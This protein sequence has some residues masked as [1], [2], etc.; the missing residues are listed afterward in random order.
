LIDAIAVVVLGGTSLMSGRGGIA[1]TEVGLLIYGTL[2]LWEQE[3]TTLKHKINSSP[4]SLTSLPKP[5]SNLD[6]ALSLFF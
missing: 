2:R 6:F 1:Q 4:N 5:K 3:E